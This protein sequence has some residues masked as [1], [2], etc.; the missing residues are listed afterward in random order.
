MLPT[1]I[2]RSHII[3]LAENDTSIGVHPLLGYFE[4]SGKYPDPTAFEQ[5]LKKLHLSDSQSLE[6]ATQLLGLLIHKKKKLLQE[7]SPEH[8]KMLDTLNTALTYLQTKLHKPP[9][10]G[11]SELFW[12]NLYLTWP[13]V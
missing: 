7:E 6:V 1:I 9:Q 11:S 8:E 4:V 3:N 2:S 5:E 10:S 13:R 12:K